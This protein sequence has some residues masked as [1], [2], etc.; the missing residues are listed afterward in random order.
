MSQLNV[1]YKSSLLMSNTENLVLG[2]SGSLISST[3]FL[4]ERSLIMVLRTAS[5]AVA[6]R[7][8]N[9]SL[10]FKIDLSSDMR[11]ESDLNASSFPVSWLLKNKHKIQY[12]LVLV[13]G[14]NVQ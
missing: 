8:T 5:V 13:G 2:L 7:V 1:S 12:Q 4:R 3:Q 10:L 9:G 6:V 11:P 14:N